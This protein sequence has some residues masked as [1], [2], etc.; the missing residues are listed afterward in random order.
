MRY[1]PLSPDERKMILELCEVK[2]FEELTA[3]IPTE[4]RLKGQ[5]DLEPALSEIELREHIADLG[6]KVGARKMQSHLGQGVYDHSW[7]AVMDQIV[8]R[9]EFL[10]AYTPYQP[11]IS[12]GTLQMI[13]EFQ[14]M[15]SGL[16]GLEVANASLYD[17][18]T[19]VV[20]AV[21]MAARLKGLKSGT[22]YVSE[23][24][25][26]KNRNLLA[27]YLEPLGFKI[28]TWVADPQTFLSQAKT[29]S[30]HDA[31]DAVAVVLQSPNKWG[32]VEDWKEVSAAGQALQC[33]SIASISHALSLALFSSPGEAGV[34][35]A[36]GEGQS[37]GIPVGFGG[38]HLG[39]FCCKKNDV[40]Q[41]PGRLVGATL[42]SK[43]QRAFCVTLSTRE[44]H[45]RRERATSNICSN[46][47]LIA[48]RAAIYLALMGP[49]G[50]KKVAD[51]SRNLAFE[52]REQLKKALQKTHS[53]I[54]VLE[55]D[56]FNEVTLL[57]PPRQSL[58][59]DE[60][61][62]RGEKEKVL[63]GL[64]VDVP[65]ASGFVGALN[66]AFTE[67][68]TLQHIEKLVHLF[69]SGGLI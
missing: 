32:L 39:L 40:R 18:A 64:R 56:L 34:D 19:A 38:P 14:S 37:L 58:W 29:L 54:Q 61:L 52:A 17:G 46:Q 13:F 33:K 59:L 15:I 25:Y 4:L 63:A 5:L 31:K 49:V 41:M 24:T 65:R 11:E 9:G 47:N 44:Q 3:N 2:S 60:V 23:G 20:E 57:A 69:S 22:V 16:M 1:L 48:L 26:G 55:G 30:G 36:V 6:A 35:I 45:I 43:G 28:E 67:K 68:H 50:L 66:V 27:T 12:Q 53:D 62:A 7:P 10:T 21:L 42:D 8:N 51:I